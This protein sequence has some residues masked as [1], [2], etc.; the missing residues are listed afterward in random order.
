M[1][2]GYGYEVSKIKPTDKLGKPPET[3]NPIVNK[4]LHELRR[5]SIA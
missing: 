1:S 3:A 5:I 2:A 4:A